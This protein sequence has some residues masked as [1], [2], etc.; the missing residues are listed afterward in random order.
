ML[1]TVLLLS[2]LVIIVNVIINIMHSD[3][4]NSSNYMEGQRSAQ[5]LNLL[6]QFAHSLHGSGNIGFPNKHQSDFL[7]PSECFAPAP[8]NTPELLLNCRVQI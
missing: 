5:A 4:L 7:D 8:L 3:V 1:Q 6:L 2:P